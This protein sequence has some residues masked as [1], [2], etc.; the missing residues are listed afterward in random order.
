MSRIDRL[1]IQIERLTYALAALS[2]DCTLEALHGMA[3]RKLM[4][5]VPRRR[6]E[7]MAA[8]KSRNPVIS[9]LAE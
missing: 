2:P 8:L 4:G 6:L 5:E 7:I 9:A 3:D 1:E